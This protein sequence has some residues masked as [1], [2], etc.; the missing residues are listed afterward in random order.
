MQDIQHALTDHPAPDELI[1]ARG[2]FAAPTVKLP[3]DL[4]ARVVK[5]TAH[6]RRAS[7]T[8]EKGAV[9]TTDTYFGLL[10]ASYFQRWTEINQLE[11]TL[12]YEASRSARITLCASDFHGHKRTVDSVR[13][14]GAGTVSMSAMLDAFVDGG[15]LWMECAAS[16]GSLTV[17][18]LV[19]TAVAPAKI[20][21]AALVICT[22]NQPEACVATVRAVA[23]DQD[24]LTGIDAVYIIDQGSEPVA[25]RAAFREVVTT[26]GDKCVYLQQRNL[27]GSGGFTRGLY[28]VSRITD[29]ANVIL[30]DDDILSE[31]ETV[32]RLNAF[33]NLT[34]T[35][36]IVGAQMLFVKNPRFLLAA[37]EMADL[38]TLRPGRWGVHGLH[39]A[40][41][42]EHRQN[43][44]VDGTYTGW[45]TCLIPAELISAAGLPLPFFIKWDD[46]EYS[47]R[48][49]TAGF[50]VVT[51][52]N[53]GV[54][55]AEFH[56]KDGDD[57]VRYFDIRN[58]LITAALHARVDIAV[59][60]KTIRQEITRNL[61]AMNYGLAHTVIRAVEDFLEGPSVLDDGGA[62]A[63]E[64]IRTE[65][66]NFLETEVHAAVRTAEL[67]GSANPPTKPTDDRRN[68][69]TF[70]M[71]KRLISHFS[72]RLIAGPVTIP[73]T[74]ATWWHVSR[75]NFAVITDASQAGVRIRRHDRHA[76][77]SLTRRAI[78]VLRRFRSEAPRVQDEYRSS[79]ARLS[80]R[81]N[82]TRLLGDD[83]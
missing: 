25:K 4:Y 28:E 48:A 2:V 6:R 50:P 18:D 38:P 26:L 66:K 62:A 8:L 75:F 15:S 11:L 27:G 20:R 1:V 42:V 74:D 47:L 34:P 61:V 60:S 65:R 24:V 7:L 23:N 31:P 73:A 46:V 9:V 12:A 64:R 16:E 43:R 36:S 33:A 59:T 39:H 32:L 81:E 49:L 37:A 72:G 69:L 14:E 51:L 76:L 3:D 82:W 77:V 71:I 13:V 17:S 5:G 41:I 57:W 40:D 70:L 44:R 52:P 45:W 21:P 55:H 30:M 78:R 29:H 63:M 79:F 83:S 10:P 19:W 80:S 54:W 22:F 67:T 58:A 56:W 35:P 68:R 53:A